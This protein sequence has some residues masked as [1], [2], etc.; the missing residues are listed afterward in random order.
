MQ[1]ILF[2]YFEN[3]IHVYCI[4]IISTLLSF[5]STSLPMFLHY[6]LNSQHLLLLLYTFTHTHTHNLLRTFSIVLMYMC[7]ELISQNW[8]SL[9]ETKTQSSILSLS[10]IHCLQLFIQESD[11]MMLLP[12]TSEWQVGVT[13]AIDLLGKWCIGVS[14]IWVQSYS[15][16]RDFLQD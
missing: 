7:L 12:Y 8:K 13:R 11:L 14:I 2:T 6:L 3:C 4:Y 10:A 9:Q 1:H 16:N 5:H 15:I